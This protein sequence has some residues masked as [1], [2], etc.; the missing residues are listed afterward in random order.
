MTQ[1]VQ[2]QHALP[3][4]Q[5]A[6]F[7]VFAISNDTVER[8]A[9]FA[10]QHSITF[11][12]L[13]DEDSAVIR[14]FGIMNTLIRPDEG[15]HMRWY[16]IPYP[17]TYVADGSGTIID[18]D[19]HQHHA[20]RLSGSAL[21]HRVLGTAPAQDSTMPQ[22]ASEDDEVSL[23][24]A[25]FDPTLRLEV[26]TAL[27]CRLHIKNERHVYAAGAPDA[28][29]PI[30][31]E[32]GGEGLRFGTQVWPQAQMLGMPELNLEVPVYEGALDV[33]VSVSATSDIIR[34]GHGLE[35]ASA[36]IEVSCTYQSCDAHACGLPTVIRSTLEV[37]LEELVEPPGTKAYAARVEGGNDAS[38]PQ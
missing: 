22:A 15:K 2:L 1:L 12:L 10:N 16:G 37:P 3:Q 17:G 6:G 38:K 4:L 9:D 7:E 32:F 20:Q 8:L 19:F 33:T 21:V 26:I 30:T 13:S 29:T 31:L 28:F 36:T 24:L 34:L 5:A 35:R 27:S 18:K 25:L 14:A 11:N 23:S